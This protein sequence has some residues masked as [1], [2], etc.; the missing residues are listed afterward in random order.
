MLPKM[1]KAISSNSRV[2]EGV[3]DGPR[4]QLQKGLAQ[5]FSLPK[6]MSTKEM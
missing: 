6:T 1:S 4:G 5:L 3:G 2:P